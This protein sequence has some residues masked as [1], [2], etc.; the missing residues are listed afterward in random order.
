MKRL[1]AALIPILAITELAPAQEP[2]RERIEWADIWVTDADNDD[3]PR[4]LLIGDSITKG[5]FGDVERRLTGKGYCARLTTSKCVSDPFF[6]DEVQLLLKQYKFAA[7][8]FNNGLHGWGYTEEQYRDGLQ[9]LMECLKAHAAGA[10]LIWATTTPIRNSG[11]L[12]QISERTERVKARNTLAAEIMK[13]RGVPTDD[14]YGLVEA[15]PEFFAGDGVHYNGKGKEAQGAAV[16][17]SV[18][19]CLG[20]TPNS[21]E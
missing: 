15:H 3:L 21:L 11:H 7:I 12:E 8:H 5:Y 17:E 6:C 20:N 18:L 9:R 14:L 19:K 10:K 2:I 13:E 16:A 1:F 4:V